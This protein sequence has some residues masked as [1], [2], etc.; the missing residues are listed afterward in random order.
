MSSPW[1]EGNEFVLLENGE[2]YYPR[3][4]EA[5]SQARTEVL[6]ET[7]ILFDDKV[8]RALRQVLI[9]AARRGVQVDITVD[10]Y[11]SD[12]LSDEFIQGLTGAG[13][14]LHVFDP[15]P[16]LMG[17][18]TNLFRR[19]HRKIVAV[20]G[21]LAFI[22]GINF[23]A[24]HLP[25]FGPMAKQDYAVQVRGPLASDMANYV[26]DVLKAARVSRRR[27]RRV[28]KLAPPKGDASGR[29]IVRDNDANPT[30]IESAYRVAIRGAHEDILIANAYFFPGYRLLRDLVDAAR[31]GV[32]VR[33]ILQGEP[34]MKV[35]QKA[36]EM[37]YDYLESAG[38]VIYEYCDRPLHGKVACID[39][40]W[41][42]V[43]SSN[44]DPFSLALNLEANV[45]IH[46]REFNQALRDNLEG[47]IDQH[48]RRIARPTTRRG[49]L[50]RRPWTSV[51]VFHFLRRFPAWAGSLPAHK[52]RL[53]SL[54][55]DAIAETGGESA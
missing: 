22:G 11:G 55:A 15:R 43:G 14:R 44:L 54:G 45:V 12:T 30:S 34:D 35:A 53:E 52:P 24:D 47:L 38:I 6:I 48:C 5:I 46:D 42:T 41:A 13:V 32:R 10:G 8:G 19:M 27:W 39:Q 16:R 3:V 28:P 17:V 4:N 7:F 1:R 20:D 31:R 37:L 9:D 21:R 51:L 36:A 40:R 33:L 25:D 26:R 18:R 50:G 29:L 49:W 23:S 2:A